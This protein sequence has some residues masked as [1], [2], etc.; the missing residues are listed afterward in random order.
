MSYPLL[1][2]Y[3]FDFSDYHLQLVHLGRIM[4][5][6]DKD[7]IA[8]MACDS[9]FKIFGKYDRGMVYRFQDDLS[10]Q[11]IHE[12]KNDSLASS[13]SKSVHG[14]EFIVVGYWD[15]LP[16]DFLSLYLSV[17]MRFPATDIPLPA[18]ELYIKNGLRYI[19]NVDAPDNPLIS[20]N[21]MEIDLTQCRMRA[22][23]K[24]HIIYL[25]NMGVVSSLSLPIVVDNELWGLLAM[26][27]YNKP[28]KPSLHQRIACETVTAMLSVRIEAFTRKEQSLRVLEL[29]EILMKWVKEKNVLHNLYL[30]GDR[31]L[32]IVDADVMVARINGEGCGENSDWITVGDKSLVPNEKFWQ[33]FTTHP[34]RDICSHSTRATITKLGLTSDDCPSSGFAYFREG[35]MEIMFGR[36][37]RSKD[38]VWAG[39]PDAP[40]LR[41]GGFL[42]P[43]AS[44]ERFMEKARMESRYW[45]AGD[46]HALGVL[47][48]HVCEQS[49]QWVMSILQSDIDQA[50][51]NYANALDRA[52]DNYEFFAH[53]S[54][55]LRTRTFF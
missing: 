20:K 45:T 18:R 39:N 34:N 5:F 2:C 13:Y 28:F 40:K 11:V 36:A 49:H 38:V 9:V 8:Q 4:E 22:V 27:G 31:L 35:R 32:E 54:H 47:R 26:H 14:N 55:E 42:H 50:N 29:G 24:P 51:K 16:F 25:R 15:D 44:F 21:G 52:R 46:L 19:L 10:G 30:V 1:L 33:T 43:R 7:T 53:M 3:L 48:D 23:A 17:G 12:I 37:L 41:Q 6:Y